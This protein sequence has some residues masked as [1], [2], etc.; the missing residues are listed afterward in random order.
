MHVSDG[1][2]LRL[3][4]RRIRLVGIDAPELAQTCLDRTGANWPCGAVA[5][6]RLAALV[7]SDVVTCHPEGEDV[8]HRILARCTASGRDIGAEQGKAGMRVSDGGY[9]P[10]EAAARAAGR[11]VWQGRFEMPRNYRSEAN[12]ADEPPFLT[13]L[14]Q[15]FK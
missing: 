2:S 15:W 1:D 9:S 11:G 3:A 14:R 7:A 8:Y 12:R 10:E 4:D 6:D 13:W 5:R